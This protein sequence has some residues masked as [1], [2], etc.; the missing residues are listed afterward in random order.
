MAEMRHNDDMRYSRA[1]GLPWPQAER[2]ILHTAQRQDIK[3][4]FK[5]IERQ[6]EKSIVDSIMAVG[7][8][9]IMD[10]MRENNPEEDNYQRGFFSSSAPGRGAWRRNGPSGL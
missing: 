10:I 2:E 5:Q 3:L 1:A 6:L 8:D 9:S 4:V 7:R